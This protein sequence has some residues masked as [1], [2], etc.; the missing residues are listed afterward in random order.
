[1]TKEDYIK[2][3]NKEFDGIRKEAL[4]KQVENF[5]TLESKKLYNQKYKV[6]DFVKLKKDTFLHG[7][8]SKVSYEVF[9][10]LAEKG[11]INKDFELGA[12]SHKIHHAVSLWH[13]MKD[14]RLADYIVNYSGMEVMIDNKEYKVVPYGKLDEFVEKMR[15]YPHWSWKAES[16]MEI[17]FMPSLAKENNQIAFIFNGRDKVCKDLTYYNLNDERISY[18]IAKGF[19][20][21]STE[22]RAQSWIENRRQGPD[23]RIAY[24]IFG[25]PK[26]M[27][28]GVLVGRKFEKNKKIL[29]HIKEKLP[30]VYIC[31]LDGKVI[32]A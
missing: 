23:T 28:E 3:I 6:G 7:L 30:N 22:E 27:I 2:I 1:M 17:R 25:L 32:V 20:K 9:D 4:L 14:I 29:K 11:L 31:N 18:D 13:I 12:S 8:G 24:I 15:K 5:Y 16:S 21:F 10:L 19:M 26:N